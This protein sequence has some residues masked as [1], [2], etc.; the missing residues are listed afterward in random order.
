MTADSFGKAA[1][2]LARAVAPRLH[3]HFVMFTDA[4]VPEPDEIEQLLHA[5]FWTS[6]RREERRFP[7]ITLA[8]LDPDPTQSAMAFAKPVALQPATLAKVSPAVV[9]AGIHLGVGRIDGK[10]MVWGATRRLPPGTF[11]LEVLQP[12]FIVVKRSSEKGKY[13]NVAIIDGDQVRFIG[14]GS[15]RRRAPP[16]IIDLLGL[17]SVS[18]MADPG[19]V[20]I[21]LATSMRA[22]TR[23]GMLLIVPASSSSW[24]NSVVAPLV[25]EVTPP[26][27]ELSKLLEQRFDAADELLWRERIRRA[28]ETIAGVTAVDGATIIDSNYDLLAFGAKLGRQGKPVSDIMLVDITGDDEPVLTSASVLGGTRHL[29]AA[30]FVHDHADVLAL[31]ASEAGHFT[32]FAKSESDERVW[33]YRVEALLL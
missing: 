10:L 17:H 24:R 13:D 22:H 19:N 1:R 8:Y 23:G 14:D 27:R 31:V 21:Q 5:A 20:T 26:F 9:R 30:Q 6:V 25:Y 16:A 3:Q 2:E 29:S 4:V 28:V 32:A 7:T 15:A 11:V 33:A 18:A 12:A